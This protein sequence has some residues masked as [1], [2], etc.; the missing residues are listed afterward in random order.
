MNK[1]GISKINY[2]GI[3]LKFTLLYTILTT[4]LIA[5]ASSLEKN[6][7]SVNI[8]NI[9]SISDIIDPYFDRL[10]RTAS[11]DASQRNLLRLYRKITYRS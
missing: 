8:E 9:T 11:M 2:L 10:V 6:N 1:I 3:I 4:L 7:N 5:P